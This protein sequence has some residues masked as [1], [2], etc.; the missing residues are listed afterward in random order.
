MNPETSI[1]SAYSAQRSTAPP[2]PRIIP[3]LDWI[4]RNHLLSGALANAPICDQGCGRL[5]HLNTLRTYSDH[6]CLVDQEIQLSRPGDLFTAGRMS[7][8]EYVQLQ[9][10]QGIDL[11]VLCAEKFQH[12]SLAF[13]LIVNIAVLDVVLPQERVRILAAA[14]RN[15]AEGGLFVLIVPRNDSS[16]LKRCSAS[17][18]YEDGH[19]FIHHGA[20][21]FFANFRDHSPL[22]AGLESCGLAPVADLSTYRQV[23]LIALKTKQ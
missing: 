1:Q 20:A 6:V 17:N 19:V 3:S 21:T 14:S 9:V 18:A 7:V 12:S 2:N 4:S 8:Y 11:S 10:R 15:L 16:I 22:V 13:R 5:R 23:C